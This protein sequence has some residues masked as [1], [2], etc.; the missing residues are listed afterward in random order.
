MTSQAERALLDSYPFRFEEG[1]QVSTDVNNFEKVRLI[2]TE[3]IRAELR[4]REQ[5]GELNHQ[6]CP[7]LI[8]LASLYQVPVFEVKPQMFPSS[9]S[10][11]KNT[12]SEPSNMLKTTTESGLN[13]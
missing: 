5:R 11:K 9:L 4:M 8:K 2:P 7:L 12:L 3:M 13:T 1:Y 6:N 10:S